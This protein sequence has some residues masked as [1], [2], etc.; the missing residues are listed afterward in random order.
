M[1]GLQPK[2]LMAA[3]VAFAALF[4]ASSASHSAP[5]Q[6]NFAGD[7]TGVSRSLL[8]RSG[9]GSGMTG[10]YRFETSTPDFNTGSAN[11]GEYND[12]I[13]GLGISIGA[14]N[15]NL[16]GGAGVSK[17]RVGNGGRDTFKLGYKSWVNTAN[18]RVGWDFKIML[19]DLDG[20]AF[21]S[22]AL[23]TPDLDEFE[24]AVWMFAYRDEDGQLL[25]ASGTLTDLDSPLL[26][27]L[28]ITPTIDVPGNEGPNGEPGNPNNPPGGGGPGG[29]QEVADVPEPASLGLLGLALAGAGLLRFRRRGRT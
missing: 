18:G 28:G 23:T 6:I 29:E 25:T 20:T 26:T 24:S 5:L 3:T 21:S 13:R 14:L 19:T 8:D 12:P 7:V 4:G 27:D 22:D 1:Q 15:L 10:Y 11:N 16:S 9:S 2:T 17:I